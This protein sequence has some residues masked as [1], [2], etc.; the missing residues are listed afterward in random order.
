MID[1]SRK[2]TLD[3]TFRFACYKGI[4]C[5]NRCCYD[6]T[7]ILMPY[8]IIR[9]KNNLGL[10]STEFLK[11][12][13]TCQIGYNSG[14]PVVLLKMRDDLRCPFVS[15]EGCTIYKDRPGPC[16]LYPLV[17]MR[18]K[19]EE[20]YFIIRESHC[21][22]FEEN[23]EWTVR[24]WLEDQGVKKY[25][26]MN[27]IFMELISAKYESQ[28]VLSENELKLF[29]LACYDVDSFRDFVV[30]KSLNVEEGVLKDDEELV[31]FGIRWVKQT[32]FDGG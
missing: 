23:R 17:R 19:D 13:T 2:L 1:N 20:Y 21:E 10:T 29:Y 3:D 22:G 24:E 8:D 27:D 5:F 30:N 16:R 26:E 11:E 25:N 4:K 7:L 9:I 14:L 28:K 15:D 18:S 31:K 12:Y 6:L 32:L